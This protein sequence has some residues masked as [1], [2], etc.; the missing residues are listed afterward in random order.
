MKQAD[1]VTSKQRT[2]HLYKCIIDGYTSM[3][4]VQK[5]SKQWGI[6]ERQIRKYIRRAKAIITKQ[7]ETSRETTKAINDS[8]LNFLYKKAISQED[9]KLAKEVIKEINNMYGVNMQHIDHT[10]KDEK[11]AINVNFNND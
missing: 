8:R 1:S 9:Y 6:G 3:E 5:Y 2:H 4:M 7:Q 11:I 10:S